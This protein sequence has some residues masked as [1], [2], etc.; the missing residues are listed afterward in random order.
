MAGEG[1]RSG[2]RWQFEDMLEYAKEAIAILDGRTLSQLGSDRTGQ[3]ALA[4]CL[5]IF[6]EAMNR[7]PMEVRKEH[8]ELP[9]K[10]GIST[11]NRLIHGYDV[12]RLDILHGV[13]SQDFPA[14]IPILEKILVDLGKQ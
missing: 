13:V 8:P 5:E 2:P 9:W 10:E 1:G 3:L 4:R 12:V 7:V 6:G 11:R 14:L